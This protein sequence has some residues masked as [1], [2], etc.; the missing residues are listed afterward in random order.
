MAAPP[1][2]PL[3]GSEVTLSYFQSQLA[4]YGGWV[5]IPG[6]GLCWRPAVQDRELGWRPYFNAGHWDYTDD[7]W[8]LRSGLSVGR[9]RFPLW[10]LGAGR[11][12]WVGVDARLR[13]GSQTC[14]VCWRNAESEGAF[15]VGR[16]AA[17]RALSSRGR[18]ALE[19]DDWL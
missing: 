8:F 2:A 12:F 4:P 9:I 18:I 1:S 13:M 15:A 3:P 11:A 14:R 7:G 19:L 5:D 17:R 6:Y 10:P 16:P